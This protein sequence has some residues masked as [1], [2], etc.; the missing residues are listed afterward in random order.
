MTYHYMYMCVV[1]LII[2]LPWRGGGLRMGGMG[3]RDEDGC[4]V[5][6]IEMG[7]VKEMGRGEDGEG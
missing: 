1:A 2:L 4:V 5:E 6:R 7:R 3:M